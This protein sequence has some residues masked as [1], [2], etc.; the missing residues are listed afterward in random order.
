MYYKI[1]TTITLVSKLN[2]FSLNLYYVSRISVYPIYLGA[3]RLNLPENTTYKVVLEEDG[4]EVDDDE[5]FQFLSNN[6]IFLLLAEDEQWTPDDQQGVLMI[7]N[8]NKLCLKSD[9]L[10]GWCDKEITLI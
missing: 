8:S 7:I 9:Y 2:I 10:P 6:T 4:T 1:Y 5:Y 3:V